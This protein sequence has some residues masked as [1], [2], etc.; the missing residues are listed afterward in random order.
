MKAQELLNELIAIKEEYGTLDVEI[1]IF[2]QDSDRLDILD[3]D[4]FTTGR[5]GELYSIDINIKSND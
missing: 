5:R 1:K 3:L 4:A 2:I